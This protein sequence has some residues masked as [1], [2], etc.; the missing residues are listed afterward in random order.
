MA[1]GDIASERQALAPSGIVRAKIDV[2]NPVL[3]LYDDAGAM[4][5]TSF[6]VAHFL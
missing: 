5:S 3:E 6:D 1:I 4:S 2:G